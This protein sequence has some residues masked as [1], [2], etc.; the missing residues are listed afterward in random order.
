M[1]YYLSRDEVQNSLTAAH[2]RIAALEKELANLKRMHERAATWLVSAGA[3]FDTYGKQTLAALEKT[4]PDQ[5][6]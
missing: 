6:S 2:D 5:R 1:K 4:S 3:F